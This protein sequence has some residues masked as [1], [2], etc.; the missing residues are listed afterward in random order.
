MRD[1]VR[2]PPGV[3][4]ERHNESAVLNVS[5]ERLRRFF[6]RTDFGHQVAHNIRE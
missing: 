5:P 1:S 4:P 2:V 3:R 6:V